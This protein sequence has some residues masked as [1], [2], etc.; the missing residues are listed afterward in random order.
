M[1]APQHK[2]T[3]ISHSCLIASK[4]VSAS[5]RCAWLVLF[6]VTFLSISAS[7][8]ANPLS[9]NVLSSAYQQAA[10]T[11]P[12]DTLVVA[13]P[14]KQK[15]ETKVERT[16]TDS[17]VQDLKNRMVHLYGNAVVVYGDIKLEAA[18]IRFNFET[19]Q[20]FAR[21]MQDSTGKLIGRPRFTDKDQTFESNELNYNFDSKKG[22]IRN[23]VTEDGQGYLLGQQVKK[24][25]DNT[26]N[27]R[28]GA[29]TTCSDHDH[30]HFEFRF[31]KSRVIPGNKIVTGPAWLVIEG[32]P[33]PLALPFGMFPNRTTRKSG[34]RI[35]TY[36][37]SNNRGFY[38]ENGGFYWAINDRMDLDLVGDIY[39]RG[40]WAIKPVFR[41][42]KRYKYNGNLNLNYAINILG[43]EGNPDYRRS[44][45]FRIRW[46]HRQDP[47]ARP[48]GRF[49]AD[50]N[51]SSSNFNAFNPSTSTDYLSNEFKSSVAYQTNFNNK[52]F[53]TANASHRQNTKTKMVEV[54]LPELTI[55]TNTL[56]PLKR[57]NAIGT[58]RWYE[59]L[60]VGYTLSARNTLSLPD[61]LFFKPDALRQMRNGIQQS[62]PVSLPIKVLKYF[63]LSNSLSIT[64]RN[65]FNHLERYWVDDTLFRNND[66]IIGYVKTDTVYRFNN[67]FDFNVS[68][69]LSTKVFGMVSFKKGP[70]RAVRHV[71]TPRIGA[72]FTPAFSDPRWG[73]Y[74]RY[75]DEKGVEQIYSKY[76]GALFGSPP[77]DKSGRIN[78]GFSNNLEMKV[79]S[80][81]DTITGVRK[82]VLI[83]DLSVS[84]GYDLARDSLNMSL[85]SVN[86]RTRL[87]K[88]LSVQY[89]SS[90]DPYAIDSSGKNINKWEWDVN[91]RLLRKT[92]ATWSLGAQWNLNQ[93]DFERKTNQPPPQRPQ[94]MATEAELTEIDRN[95]DMFIDWSI[96]WTL[97]VNYTLR[98]NNTPHY[99][100]QVR[101]GQNKVVQTLGFSGDISITPRW[102]IQAQSGWDFEAKGL[103]YTSVNIYRDLHCWEIRFNWIP[104]GFRKSWNFTINA[105]SSVLQDLKLTRKK[106]FR[107]F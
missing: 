105:K 34:V 107:D 82:V 52:V 75:I 3:H 90:W 11:V 59:A 35:P 94:S 12:T 79:R 43:V 39:T 71:F 78:F 61:S 55:N 26:I 41:Y 70:V 8:V 22:I 98:Y 44:R 45:D 9:I 64:N 101:M 84:G 1:Y 32:M 99:A 96:P 14:V 89:S 50:V 68:S 48:V 103:S 92:N 49:S 51:V 69:N 63:S 60:T 73:Y 28:S 88:N 93:K 2:Y 66:T 104:L 13:A 62:V 97:S 6:I 23:V 30:P 27:I 7:S 65:Y 47:K 19:N 40:S 100:G 80:R 38:F 18:Y 72:S 56:Y 15:L 74:G 16:A 57:K 86:G 17:I 83:E 77:R 91:R 37:E 29:Y 87:L 24:M 5:G 25:A 106:D 81:K 102:K 20:V 76:E 46:S 33:L 53:L 67:V 4:R 36:G 54:S 42:V 10:D 31:N 95:P 85:I 21:G 58:P